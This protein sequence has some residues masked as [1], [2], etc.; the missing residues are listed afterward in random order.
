M[1]YQEAKIKL[2]KTQ[3]K[4]IKNGIKYE[5]KITPVDEN[6]LFKFIEHYRINK[7]IEPLKYSSG[8]FQILGL[9]TDGVNVLKTNIKD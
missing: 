1:N 2:K 3:S 7:N 8:K 9:W 5:T 6:E 4:I